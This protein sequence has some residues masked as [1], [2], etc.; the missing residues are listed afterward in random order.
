[1]RPASSQQANLSGVGLD[2][3]VAV[4]D[5]VQVAVMVGDGLG[6]AVKISVGKLV[7]VGANV[8]GGVCGNGSASAQADTSARMG[9]IKSRSD[10]R[11]K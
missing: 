2:V 11:D 10:K 8:A 1:M 6:V 7:L 5:C 4:A 9:M 3:G